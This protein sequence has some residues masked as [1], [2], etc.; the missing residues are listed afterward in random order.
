MQ[1]AYDTVDD[2]IVGLLSRLLDRDDLAPDV[3]CRLLDAR[4]A[5]LSGDERALPQAAQAAALARD[6]GDPRLRVLTLFTLARELDVP[7][8]AR[9]RE[10]AHELRDLGAEH[11]MPAARWSGTYNLAALAVHEQRPDE[12]RRRVD[13]AAELARR[14]R[15]PEAAAVS[16]TAAAA[17]AHAAGRLDERRSPLPRGDDAMAAQGSLHATGFALL[18]RATLAV[19]RGTLHAFAD[20]AGDV[21]SDLLPVVADILA[22]AHAAA[23]RPDEARRLHRSA[24]TAHPGY[25][26]TTFRTFRAMTV[27]ALGDA[28]E[29]AEVYEALLPYRDGPPA[30][31]ESL[32]VALPPPARTL[33]DLARMLGRDPSVHLERAAEITARWAAD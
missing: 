18:A 23:G 26:F 22:A 19:S 17:L 16:E 20:E 28:A 32:S 21:P 27:L 4:A 25:F 10:C 6:L 15:M 9:M 33:A 24:L 13:E 2:R 12:A 3:R 8:T 30:G 1:R 14:Y 31:L 7:D 29:A 11:D 5:E